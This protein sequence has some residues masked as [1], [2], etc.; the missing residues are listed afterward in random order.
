MSKF[1]AISGEGLDRLELYCHTCI[2]A[3]PVLIGYHKVD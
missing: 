2:C 3:N 1:I